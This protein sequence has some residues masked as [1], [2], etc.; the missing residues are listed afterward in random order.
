MFVC[1]RGPTWTGPNI[2]HQQI[3][4]TVMQNSTVMKDSTVMEDSTVAKL[5]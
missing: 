3:G 4:P 1:G 5:S 2:C